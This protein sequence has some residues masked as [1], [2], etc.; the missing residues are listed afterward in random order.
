M[1]SFVSSTSTFLK[2]FGSLAESRIFKCVG[3][4]NSMF[5]EAYRIISLAEK[6]PDVEPKACIYNCLVNPGERKHNC[7][8]M[9]KEKLGNLLLDLCVNGSQQYSIAKHYIQVSD[10]SVSC[11]DNCGPRSNELRWKC[12]P[13]LSSSSPREDISLRLATATLVLREEVYHLSQL[14]LDIGGS[15]GLFLGIS[16]IHVVNFET[17]L[18]SPIG[19]PQEILV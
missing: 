19:K 8:A 14:L 12:S 15:L 5:V 3:T 18:K 10:I 11:V 17:L 9:N 2:V 1:F 6:E 7:K 13:G 16:I 4:G